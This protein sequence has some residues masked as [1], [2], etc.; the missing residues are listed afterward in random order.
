MAHNSANISARSSSVIMQP[1]IKNRWNN[2]F[3]KSGRGQNGQLVDQMLELAR[4]IPKQWIWSPVR[5]ARF[6]DQA[7]R[8]CK[9]WPTVQYCHDNGRGLEPVAPASI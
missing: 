2:R 8:I 5:S 6:D 3:W 7:D 9:H 4:A 1:T